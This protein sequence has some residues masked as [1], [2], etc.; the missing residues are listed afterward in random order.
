MV[1]GTHIPPR[2]FLAD[3]EY[4]LASMLANLLREKGWDAR[5]F[6]DPDEALEAAHSAP[7]TCWFV[8]SKSRRAPAWSSQR[9]CDANPQI[10]KYSSSQRT[11]EPTAFLNLF[12]PRQRTSSFSSVLLEQIHLAMD[13]S[14]FQIMD[15][16]ARLAN[17]A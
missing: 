4:V 2:S 7:Q 3:E 17:H 9:E 8:M 1:L 14:H 13:H 12:V 16:P 6:G 11:P 10:A 5:A 15:E